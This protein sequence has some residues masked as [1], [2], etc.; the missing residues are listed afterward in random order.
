MSAVTI[1]PAIEAD[2]PA[3]RAMLQAASLPIDDLSAALLRGFVL[4]EWDSELIATGGVEY[5]GDVGLLRSLVVSTAHR[6]SGQARRV[7]EALEQHAT[8]QGLIALY[9]LTITAADY[10]LQLGYRRIE[11]VEAPQ[12]I[13]VTREFGALCPAS[14]VLMSKQLQP[15]VFKVLFLCTAN[16]ARSILAEAILN[17]V[18]NGRERF[19]AHS[20]GSHP[21]GA[22]NPH[23]LRL[24]KAK[25]IP[26]DALRS[27]S[28]DEFAAPGAPT[29]DFVI[30]VCDQAAGE[31]CPY[32]PGAPVTAHWGL[33]DPAAAQGEAALRAA[34]EQAYEVLLRRIE[35]FTALPLTTLNAVALKAALQSIAAR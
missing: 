16:S 33:P 3:L 35:C 17:H 22:A 13:R 34:F 28:W 12:S 9:L 25:G 24:L 27:K 10:F 23:A 4:A 26:T 32:W 29:M 31:I 2:L 5:C 7:V 30:T 6:R 8:R 19:R 1:R 11:R 14:A 18:A 20:A 15:R 21:R